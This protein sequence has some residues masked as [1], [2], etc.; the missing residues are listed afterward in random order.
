[1][2]SP[3]S[4]FSELARTCILAAMAKRR[5]MAL[6]PASAAA[7]DGFFAAMGG[8]VWDP[9]GRPRPE[10][11][12]DLIG[13]FAFFA[14]LVPSL[15][16]GLGVLAVLP[17]MGLM[18]RPSRAGPGPEAAE[19]IERVVMMWSREVLGEDGVGVRRVRR[20]GSGVAGGVR[21]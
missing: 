15:L 14:T 4:S 11:W 19:R 13:S 12:V 9:A 17:F 18:P 3:T 20:G 7:R 6:P 10:W 8:L 21:G 5:C 2:Y 16:F 1:M